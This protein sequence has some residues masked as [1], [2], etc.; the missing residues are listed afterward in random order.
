VFG[1]KD[2][3]EGAFEKKCKLKFKEYR[4]GLGVV[5]KKC[6]CIEHYWKADKEQ[7]ECK[8]CGFRTTLRSGTFMEKSRLPYSYW[9]ISMFLILQYKKNITALEAQKVLGHKFYKPVWLMI[10]RLK[11]M[12]GGDKNKIKKIILK[13]KSSPLPLFKDNWFITNYNE[14]LKKI[15]INS[16]KKKIKRHRV[17]R[18]KQHIIVN[19]QISHN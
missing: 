15:E 19:H 18:K 14:I 4:E 3:E 1:K 16:E 10:A 7:Y 5:C 6:G 8:N 2:I 12:F 9:F 11:E 17:F 13:D